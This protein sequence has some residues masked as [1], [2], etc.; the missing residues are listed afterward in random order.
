[1]TPLV[2]TLGSTCSFVQPQYWQP[3]ER[4]P[5]TY[6]G[7]LEDT[8]FAIAGQIANFGYLS[9]GVTEGGGYSTLP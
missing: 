5:L 9:G 6:S 7:G 2:C 1:M 3:E 8:V 4:N